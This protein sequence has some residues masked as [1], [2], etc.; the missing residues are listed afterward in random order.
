MPGRRLQGHLIVG[1]NTHRERFPDADGRPACGNLA[2]PAID[3]CDV[4]SVG[5]LQGNATILRQGTDGEEH[6]KGLYERLA[7]EGY[8]CR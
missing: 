3:G 6:Q 5:S 1:L 4:L 2:A 8:S 7:A